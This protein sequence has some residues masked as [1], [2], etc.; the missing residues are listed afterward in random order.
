MISMLA[1]KISSP[2]LVST[3][4]LASRSAGDLIGALNART[5]ASGAVRN[6]AKRRIKSRDISCLRVCDQTCNYWLN[7]RGQGE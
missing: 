7:L 1:D 3:G 5:Y 2:V 4:Q 6:R